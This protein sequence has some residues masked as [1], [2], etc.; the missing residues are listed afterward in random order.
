ME[1]IT[2]PDS[3]STVLLTPELKNLIYV[4]WPQN[5]D[6]MSVLLQS[7]LFSTF[8][9]YIDELD[10]CRSSW[11]TCSFLLFHVEVRSWHRQWGTVSSC[12]A[13]ALPQRYVYEMTSHKFLFIDCI[14]LTGNKCGRCRFCAT[15][16]SGYKLRSRPV[17]DS[18][19]RRDLAHKRDDTK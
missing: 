16:T 9:K 18:C 10:R 2:Q 11:T 4:H 1:S 15:R 5:I 6:W 17:I 12:H 7:S 13:R 8:I 14:E 3:P 19:T